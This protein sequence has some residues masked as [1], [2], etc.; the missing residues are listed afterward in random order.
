MALNSLK[1]TV[2]EKCWHNVMHIKEDAE[3]NISLSELRLRLLGD[4]THNASR[5]VLYLLQYIEPNVVYEETDVENWNKELVLNYT[6]E[7]GEEFGSEYE[8]EGDCM[9]S[10]IEQSISTDQALI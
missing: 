7:N 6:E 4:E 3:E 2:I 10:T 1:R 8:K 5:V 9:F